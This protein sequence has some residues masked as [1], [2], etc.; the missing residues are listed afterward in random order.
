MTLGLLCDCFQ[1]PFHCPSSSHILKKHILVLVVQVVQELLFK[2]E[3]IT[4][5]LKGHETWIPQVSW[6][7]K[8]TELIKTQAIHE[9]FRVLLKVIGLLFYPME[10]H[11]GKGFLLKNT[12]KVKES[13]QKKKIKNLNF[14]KNHSRLCHCFR[15]RMYPAKK[16]MEMIPYIWYVVQNTW[17]W[18]TFET[19][20]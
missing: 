9:L 16:S 10:L 8:S 4:C 13:S 19:W 18:H 14:F 12:R 17:D 11:S 2:T 20:D 3:D 1:Q 15:N 6:N 5:S 7:R